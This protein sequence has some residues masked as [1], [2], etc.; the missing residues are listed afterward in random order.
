MKFNNKQSF[1]PFTIT[2]E[3]EDEAF[4]LVCAI[5]VTVFAN[6]DKAM[7]DKEDRAK[8]EKIGYERFD[9]IILSCYKGLKANI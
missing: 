2:L 1:V 4:A 3:D 5:G 9:E 6:V 7:F 8:L